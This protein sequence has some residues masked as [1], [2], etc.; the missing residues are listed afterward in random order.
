M[1]RFN[2]NQTGGLKI[3]TQVLSRIQD[4]YSIINGVAKMAGDKA[5]LSGCEVNGTNVSN[6][7]VVINGETLDFV[8]GIL[9][10]KVIIVEDISKA[11]F[12]DGSVKSFE[13]YRYA[14]FG[15]SD[16]AINWADFKRVPILNLIPEQIENLQ[17]SLNSKINGLIESIGFLKKGNIYIGDIQGNSEGWTYSEADYTISL[18]QKNIGSTSGG[19]DYYQITFVKPLSTPNY[20]I[21]TSINYSGGYVDNNDVIIAI[22]N[23]TINGFNLSARE[24]SPIIQNIS[25]DYILFEK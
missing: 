2:F 22:T 3:I 24:V 16:S 21:F 6:G 14:M 18:L 15:F 11:V 7:T 19:D 8:G 4:A 5:I 25:I 17:T 10:T 20:N 23:K 13:T 1:I 12:K 9:Q